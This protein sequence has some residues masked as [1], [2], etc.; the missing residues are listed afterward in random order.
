MSGIICQCIEEKYCTNNADQAVI[1]RNC[2]LV[3]TFPSFKRFS[4]VC[5]GLL[6]FSLE[7]E[8]MDAALGDH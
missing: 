3:V 7:I 1:S 8:L 2:F 5:C 6:R 4:E